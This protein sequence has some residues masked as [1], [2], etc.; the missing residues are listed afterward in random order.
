[1]SEPDD[2]FFFEATEATDTE[3]LRQIGSQLGGYARG[4][5]PPRPADWREILDALLAL[6]EDRPVTVAIADRAG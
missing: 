3:S 5:V 1:M 2:G 4:S 6:G